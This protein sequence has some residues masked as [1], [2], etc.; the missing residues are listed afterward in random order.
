MAASLYHYGQNAL[1][2]FVVDGPCL[3]VVTLDAPCHAVA[4]QSVISLVS[5]VPPTRRRMA[6][7]PRWL[8]RSFGRHRTICINRSGRDDLRQHS[9]R[10]GRGST[11]IIDLTCCAPS[12]LRLVRRV[13]C[14]RHD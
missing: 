3:I 14:L 7:R 10:G 9:G 4:G 11:R 1:R 6:M 12:E 5:A 8:N 13:D 2:L